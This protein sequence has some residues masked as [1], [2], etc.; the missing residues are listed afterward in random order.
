MQ[1]IERCSKSVVFVLS[2][3]CVRCEWRRGMFAYVGEFEDR[4]S[5]G[6]R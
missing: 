3:V 1:F 6:Q 4:S 2:A 5:L